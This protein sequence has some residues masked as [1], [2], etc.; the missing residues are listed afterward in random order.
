[1]NGDNEKKIVNNLG[2]VTWNN[3]NTPNI[4]NKVQCDLWNSAGQ[5]LVA[6]FDIFD[7]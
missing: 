5:A 4:A 6:P 7:D 3:N 2:N 1:M